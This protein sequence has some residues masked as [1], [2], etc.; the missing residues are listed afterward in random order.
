M[1]Q[2]FDRGAF[3]PAP[4]ITRQ[5]TTYRM[6]AASAGWP[7]GCP[8]RRCLRTANVTIEDIMFENTIIA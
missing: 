1:K 3:L 2:A 8:P 6:A 7:C 5:T 4:R